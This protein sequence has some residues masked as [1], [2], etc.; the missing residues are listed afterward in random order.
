M[1]VLLGLYGFTGIWADE[2]SEQYRQQRIWYFWGGENKSKPILLS[3]TWKSVL[4]CMVEI[5]QFSGLQWFSSSDALVY[6]TDYE[7]AVNS[8]SKLQSSANERAELR[9]SAQDWRVDL[10]WPPATGLSPGGHMF[11]SARFPASPTLLLDQ[12]HWYLHRMGQVSFWLSPFKSD[13]Y[14]QAM[15]IMKKL[16]LGSNINNTK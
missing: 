3:L 7:L 5:P 13:L 15:I 4:N 12:L 16:L 14:L 2:Y 8:K 11:T 10:D 6:K 9:S 1:I